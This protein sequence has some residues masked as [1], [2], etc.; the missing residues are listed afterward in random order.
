MSCFN[1]WNGVSITAMT[2]VFLV[3][4]AL[5]GA[6]TPPLELVAVSDAVRVFEDGYGFTNTQSQSQEINV[7]G[8]RSETISAQCV[9]RAGRDLP[10]LTATLTSLK[11]EGSNAQI[12][13]ENLTWRF[14]TD[15]L[16]LTNTPRITSIP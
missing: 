9:V 3:S 11:K 12:P 15:V 7:F 2:A 1:R 5:C 13:V 16:V 6:D 10:K 8:L 4:A 14:V